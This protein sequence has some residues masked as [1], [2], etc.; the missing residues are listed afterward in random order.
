MSWERLGNVARDGL[1]DRWS[2][3]HARCWLHVF[4]LYSSGASLKPIL[5]NLTKSNE[6]AFCSTG[7]HTTRFDSSN[8]QFEVSTMLGEFVWAVMHCWITLNVSS[9]SC[10][11]IDLSYADF[12]FLF[13]WNRN[14]R[15][16]GLSAGRFSSD[17]EAWETYTVLNECMTE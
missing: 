1:D 7:S 15:C 3:S 8:S 13:F 6:Y 9:M 17:G 10:L 12:S 11:R 5:R 14:P 2:E 4:N 16:Y